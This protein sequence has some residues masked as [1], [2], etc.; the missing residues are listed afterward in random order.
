M[1]GY[2]HNSARSVRG[3]HVVAYPYGY[4]RA[5]YGVDCVCARECARLVLIEVSSLKFRLACAGLFIGCNFLALFWRGYLVYKGMFGC[6]HAVGSAEER[7]AARGEHGEFF[8]RSVYSEVNVG[9]YRFAYPVALCRLGGLGPV[10]PVKPFQK[11]LC[12]LIYVDYPL[13]HILAHYGVTAA[14]ALTVYNLVVGKH[15][16]ELLAPVDRHVGI[17]G[18]SCLIELLEYPLRP[19]VVG[20]VAGGYRL[21]VVVG[22]AEHLQLRS[23]GLYIF[24]CEIGGVVAR[25]D[26]VLLGRQTKRIEPDGVQYVVALHSLHSGDYVCC[27]IA[28][29]VADVQSRAG[30]VGEHIQNV[31]FGFGK[32]FKVG[33][34]GIVFVPILNPFLFNIVKIC[35]GHFLAP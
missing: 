5:V 35:I 16:A 26:C 2:C 11:S 21:S 14:L 3:E 9:A 8:V 15:G 28:L 23:K 19:F 29:G 17:A 30:G 7:I 25:L 34:E 20:G 12:I 24:L 32:V 4:F 6:K 10:K 13:F 22:K 31:V 33:V 27:R 1:C 18:K